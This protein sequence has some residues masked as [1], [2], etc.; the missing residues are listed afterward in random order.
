[1]VWDAFKTSDQTGSFI[2]IAQGLR[3]DGQPIFG[4]TSF[5]VAE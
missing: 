2:I 1:V 4:T 5:E 3:G